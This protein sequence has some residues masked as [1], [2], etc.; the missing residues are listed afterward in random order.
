MAF[1][2]PGVIQSHASMN[3]LFDHITTMGVL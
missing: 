1:D 3:I 2:E